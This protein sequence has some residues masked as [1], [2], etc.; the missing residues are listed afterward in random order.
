MEQGRVN[1]LELGYIIGIGDID[2]AKIFGAKTGEA[3][4]RD[5]DADFLDTIDLKDFGKDFLLFRVEG[6][7]CQ[8]FRVE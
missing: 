6:K 5:G 7:E 4:F 3:L 8:I 1:A 2:R